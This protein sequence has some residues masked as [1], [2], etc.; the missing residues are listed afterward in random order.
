MEHLCRSLAL[1]FQTMK[2]TKESRCG[3]ALGLVFSH[4][5]TKAA[6][7]GILSVCCVSFLDPSSELLILPPAT[8]SLSHKMP[9]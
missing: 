4:S 7:G 5:K 3:Q 1:H 9:L 2:R 8:D 6:G